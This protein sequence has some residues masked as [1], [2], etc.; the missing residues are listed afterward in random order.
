MCAGMAVMNHQVA[1]V[2]HP[3]ESVGEYEDRVLLVEKGVAQKQEGAGE[4]KP[5]E[6]GWDNH[7]FQLLSSIPLDKET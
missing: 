5:P 3:G 1:D 6:R 7:P 2:R 4:T